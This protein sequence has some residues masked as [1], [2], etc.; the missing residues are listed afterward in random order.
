MA[1]RVNVQ[2]AETIVEPVIVET[3]LT[4]TEEVIA[5]NSS[6]KIRIVLNPGIRAIRRTSP[7]GALVSLDT[8]TASWLWSR[9]VQIVSVSSDCQG[10]YKHQLDIDVAVRPRSVL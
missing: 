4:E 9:T 2:V 8:V 1:E 3:V 6:A 10:F 5:R 7:G